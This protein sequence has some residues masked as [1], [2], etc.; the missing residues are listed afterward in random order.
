MKK[1]LAMALVLSSSLVSI[2]AMA[3]G[4]IAAGKALVEKQ[5]CASCHGVDFKTPTD[6]SYPKLA[7][8][9]VDY[10]EHA[11]ISYKRGTAANGRVNGVM[12]AQV[13]PLS[14]KDI[15]DIAAYLHSL[16]GTLVV[17]R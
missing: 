7:G 12:D 2:N 13:K 9:H 6:P 17:R 10:L 8:Q 11:L 14:G 4:N 3:G 16:P 5:N 15:K 1:F